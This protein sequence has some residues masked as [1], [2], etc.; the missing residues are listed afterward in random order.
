MVMAAVVQQQ[1]GRHSD[2]SN[3]DQ[4]DDGNELLLHGFYLSFCHVHIYTKQRGNRRWRQHIRRLSRL[5]RISICA[6]VMHARSFRILDQN[7]NE[8]A[9]HSDAASS[10]S[11]VEPESALSRPVSV[12]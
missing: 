8:E 7:E 9:H 4:R 10:L 12:Y 11:A 1:H 3:N 5:H 2:H 6:P